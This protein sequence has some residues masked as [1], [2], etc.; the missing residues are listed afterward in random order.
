MY[1]L[2][3]AGRHWTLSVCRL[4]TRLSR[5]RHQLCLLQYLPLRI[6][7]PRWRR[8][9]CQ[10]LRRPGFHVELA[11]GA[12]VSPSTPMTTPLSRDPDSY[13][14]P[15]GS[16]PR[17]RAGGVTIAER[18]QKYRQP[19]SEGQQPKVAPPPVPADAIQASPWNRPKTTT[20]KRRTNSILRTIQKRKRKS[21]CRRGGGRGRVASG[22]SGFTDLT[23][24]SGDERAAEPGQSEREEEADEEEGRSSGAGSSGDGTAVL[25][26][27]PR[28]QSWGAGPRIVTRLQGQSWGAG[29]AGQPAAETEASDDEEQGE[30]LPPESEEEL[31][32]DLDELI[33][34]DD[35]QSERTTEEHASDAE[36][37]TEEEEKEEDEDEDDEE[38]EEEEAERA[39]LGIDDGPI[40][41]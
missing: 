2:L 32:L 22:R 7:G 31:E 33:D 27:R 29:I 1:S 36:T 25:H 3:G 39:G 9:Q 15:E 21:Q 14:T 4:C 38:V 41:R 30:E 12:D 19:T 16:T 24:D 37:D 5:R 26:T 35:G 6:S 10:R 13:R 18:R 28:G 17:Q 20:V 11:G 23:D 40:P 34:V 8:R